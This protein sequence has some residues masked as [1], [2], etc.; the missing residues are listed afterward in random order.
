LEGFLCG[1]FAQARDTL[2]A[3]AII[4]RLFLD[5]VSRLVDP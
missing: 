5:F 1:V 2:V 4:E 3:G